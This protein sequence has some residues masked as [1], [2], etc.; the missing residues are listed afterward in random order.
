M[1]KIILFAFAFALMSVSTFASLIEKKVFKCSIMATYSPFQTA[2][3]QYFSNSIDFETIV[4]SQVNNNKVIKAALS[5]SR[6][7]LSN[8][9]KKKNTVFDLILMS[10]TG[11]TSYKLKFNALSTKETRLL[12]SEITQQNIP[13]V[14]SGFKPGVLSM[15]RSKYNAKYPMQTTAKQIYLKNDKDSGVYNI[16][17]SCRG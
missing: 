17:L 11:G 5:T 13:E 2:N 1:K 14:K 8:T 10:Y 12:L 9:T 15:K 4:T 6:I 3:D 16:Y 7:S